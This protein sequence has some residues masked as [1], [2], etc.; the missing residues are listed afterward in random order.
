MDLVDYRPQPDGQFLFVYQDHLTKSVLS[1]PF[2]LKRA[3]Q[4]AYNLHDI[5]HFRGAPSILQSD[6]GRK[7]S[8]EF[9]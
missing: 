5:F 7:F 2:T 6:N 8:N 3:D 4:I 1:K 9:L